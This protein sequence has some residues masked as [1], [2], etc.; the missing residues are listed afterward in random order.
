MVSLVRKCAQSLRHAP[1]LRRATPVWAGLRTPYRRLLLAAGSRHGIQVKVGETSMR[2][3]P[4]FATQ[5]WETLEG[6][7]YRAFAAMLRP[8]DVVFDIGAH[9]GTYSL[10]AL[11]LIGPEGRVVAYEPH[12]FTRNHLTRHIAWAGGSDRTVVRAVGCGAQ[13][14]TAAFYCVPGR[15]EGMNGFVPVAGFETIEVDVTTVDREVS[16]LKLTP[17][18]IKIDVEG[19]EWAVLKGAERTLR[20]HHPGLSLSLHPAALHR[21]GSSEAEILDWLNVLGYRHRVI[22]EDHE[23]HVIAEATPATATM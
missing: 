19:A 5:N 7:S 1:L 10:T 17:S 2:L 6:E 22:S 3:H 8:G 16:L 9:I 15:A 14:G 21:V 11:D 23:V 4:E 18:V 13:S 20:S 12:E